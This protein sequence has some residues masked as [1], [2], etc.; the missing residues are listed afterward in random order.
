[1][2]KET[3][4]WVDD[5]AP[6]PAKPRT[7]LGVAELKLGGGQT[8][9]AVGLVYGV[10]HR[11][12]GEGFE[13]TLFLD[14]YNQRIKI[15]DYKADDFGNFILGVRGLAEANQF[16][17]II[18]MAGR[19]DWQ[20]FLRHGYVLEAVI[21]Y[22]H[23][24][25]DAFAVSKFRSQ[26]RLHSASMMEEI[27]L[28]ESVMNEPAGAKRKALPAGMKIRMAK[29][30]DIPQL[31]ELYKG[32]F[33]SYPS[34]LIHQ[35]Y[36]ETIF[37]TD[38]LFAVCMEGDRIAA[39]A[40]AELSPHNLAAELTDCATLPEKRGQ[41]LMSHILRFL[42]KELVSRRYR[43][44]YTMARARSFGMN[45]VFHQ[46]GYEFMGRMTNNC[47]IFGAFEDMNIW[48]RSLES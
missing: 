17:K 18:C 29:K 43:C 44:A 33:A 30:E 19:D 39:A 13:A 45:M 27:L 15:L 23:K 31:I 14:V 8:L 16:D 9:K 41:G 1:M 22:Y 37:Q 24:G 12:A 7:N 28:I 47:D 38:S 2:T 20:Q 40:S 48:V 21:K 25:K 26:E 46:L 6:A 4:K 42:E 10:E 35:S 32:V 34:P 11:L 36:L 5:L 3:R